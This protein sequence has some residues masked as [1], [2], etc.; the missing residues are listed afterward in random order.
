MS[1]ASHSAMG[2]GHTDHPYPVIHSSKV[3]IPEM[4]S[5]AMFPFSQSSWLCTPHALDPQG[6]SS[7]HKHVFPGTQ[8]KAE[9]RTQVL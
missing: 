5:Q 3:R 2:P 8:H 6:E 1:T 9:L 4:P 7:S